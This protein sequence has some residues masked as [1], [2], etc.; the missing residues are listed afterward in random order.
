[1]KVINIFLILF[2]VL[3]VTVSGEDIP[4]DLDSYRKVIMDSIDAKVQNKK[5]FDGWKEGAKQ[6]FNCELDHL[7]FTFTITLV[8][9]EADKLFIIGLV[10]IT[11]YAFKDAIQVKLIQSHLVIYCITKDKIIES[12]RIL[13]S[14]KPKLEYGWFGIPI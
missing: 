6:D 4:N 12:S 14:I 7:G 10:T 9:R 11:G 13:E 8:K 2:L 1:M 5:T 3:G